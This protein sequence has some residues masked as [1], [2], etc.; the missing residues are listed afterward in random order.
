[1]QL[2]LR[3]RPTVRYPLLRN[4][5]NHLLH[6]NTRAIRAAPLITTSAL[7][8]NP[9]G[10]GLDLTLMATVNFDNMNNSC[11]IS[12]FTFYISTSIVYL[13]VLGWDL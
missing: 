1:M 13:P 6:S 11:P 7:T 4:G 10:L 12:L 2:R 5:N 9:K 3:N 8:L